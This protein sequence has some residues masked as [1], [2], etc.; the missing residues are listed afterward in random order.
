MALTQSILTY[1]NID[2]Q[3]QYVT[4][5]YYDYKT[6]SCMHTCGCMLSIAQLKL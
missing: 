3:G 5:C 6:I 2:K 4:Y 1:Q